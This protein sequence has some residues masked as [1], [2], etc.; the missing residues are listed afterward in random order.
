M[1]DWLS[2]WLRVSDPGDLALLLCATVIAGLIRGF[3]G[4]GAGM[5]F[6]P[7]VAT[8]VGPAAAVGLIWTVDSPITMRY[9]ITAARGSRWQDIAPLLLG[10]LAGLPVGMKLL[11]GLDP[12]A[13]R[14]ATAAFILVCV[15]VL[16][17]GWRYR[18]AP[19]V[20]LSAAVGFVSGITTGLIGIGGPF[21]AVFWL[22]GAVDGDTVKRNLNAY[23]GLLTLTVGPAFVASGII[24]ADVVM[25]AI[26][27]VVIYTAAVLVGT[28]GYNRAGDRS[29]RP[30][31]LAIAAA[32]AAAS[33]PALDPWLR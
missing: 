19:G 14:W 27:L 9:A 11:I 29:Y 1:L 24:D 18:R 7:L 2:T 23:F 30:V 32:A 10:A 21:I 26:P 4:F 6:V 20:Y 22:G 31:A 12:T 13:L 25:R 5:I 16:S 15:A 33:M 3:V 28:S 17:S 8:V